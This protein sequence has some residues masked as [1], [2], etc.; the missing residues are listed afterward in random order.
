MNNLRHFT[1]LLLIAIIFGSCEDKITNPG[2]FSIKSEL[3]IV[4]VTDTLGN[5][6][7]VEITRS[8]RV[9]TPVS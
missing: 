7:P 2:D 6:Y 9:V 4:S 1:A 8:I 3:Q 5:I